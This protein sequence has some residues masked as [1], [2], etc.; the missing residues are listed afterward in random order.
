MSATVLNAPINPKSVTNEK[1]KKL[2]VNPN[3]IAIA[4]PKVAPLEMPKVKGVVSGFLKSV[5]KSSPE[6][7]SMPP[8]KNAKMVL[9]SLICV[10]I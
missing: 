3:I 5:W 2:L 7:A 8:L 6:S 9:G 4:A 10:K 1:P